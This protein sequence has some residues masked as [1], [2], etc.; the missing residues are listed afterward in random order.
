VVFPKAVYPLVLQGEQA[1]SLL[2][3]A[4]N[5]NRLVALFLQREG[6]GA[7][8]SAGD[9]YRVGT[10]SRLSEI[11]REPDG[12]IEVTAEGIAPVQLLSIKQWNPH[13]TAEVEAIEPLDEQD[14]ALESLAARTLEAYRGLVSADPAAAARLQPVIEETRDPLDVAYLVAATIPISPSARQAI[15]EARSPS[16]KLLQL[17]TFL[18]KAQEISASSHPSGEPPRNVVSLPARSASLDQAVLDRLDLE[19]QL[20]DAG[21]PPAAWRVAQREL[22][23]FSLLTPSSPDYNLVRTYLQWLAD[24]PWQNGSE[25]DIDLDRA[26]A[27]LD[28]D[29][30]GLEEVKLRIIEHL[31]VRK[32]RRQRANDNQ[33]GCDVETLPDV[34]STSG[35]APTQPVLCLVGPP[36]VGK[37]SLGRSISEALNRPF[38]RISLGG[39]SD[40]A[41]IRGHRRTYLGAM[42]GRIV[43]SLSRVES[44]QP[45]MMLDE[46]DK[47]GGNGKGDPTA[48]LLDV[49][50]PEQQ[51]EFVDH[52]IEVPFDV[53]CVFFLA[54]ANTLE[55]V[56]EALRDRLEVI[57]L[58]GYTEEEKAQIAARHLVPR[59]MLWH[60]LNDGDMRWE[61]DAIL[62]IIRS[63]TRE[64]GVRQLEREIATVCR[65]VATLVAQDG[66]TT[67]RFPFVID[68]A[69]VT[70]V[71]GTPRFLPAEPEATD[72]PGV[73]TGVFWTPVG[74]DIMH[75]EALMM[76]GS[77]TLTITGQ[78]GEVMR[79]SAQ[80]ALS[81]VRARAEDLRI[82]PD[83][84]E[85]H[86]LHLHIPSG[87]VAK[88]GPSAGIALAV[89]I[90]SL[91]TD[92][93]VSGD[94]AMTG[95]ITL[96]GR[97]LPVGGI[98]EKVL[99]A[100][101]AGVHKV[102]LPAQNRRD[103]DDVQPEILQDLELIF[104][105]T[106]D[107]VLAA[108]FPLSARGL[109]ASSK[110]PRKEQANPRA[111]MLDVPSAARAMHQQ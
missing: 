12:L 91:L 18:N 59:Q 70:D 87:A 50:D 82:A 22:D 68:S 23:R 21:M 28:R 61:P 55:S 65:R 74:G 7:E 36:G 81:Y 20:R 98:K 3:A 80:T 62:Q 107:E 106:M 54:T 14:P 10:L 26:R 6:V 45:V 97:V 76:P 110:A 90:V 43:Q 99:A 89:A 42:P 96:R 73:V 75:I 72:Q 85:R 40:E 38:V 41:E 39:V 93:P 16:A 17:L 8:P 27:I 64:A 109:S 30:Y 103:L 44:S 33:A 4:E 92:T 78:L 2:G 83:F 94:V 100:R 46:L 19:K 95:E 9:L 15:L 1:E 37:T 24:L 111:T 52:F 13:V 11:K 32:L 108:A 31:A 102:V 60:A 101:R 77:K 34:A 71:L 51:T 56:P 67:G 25:P 58:S 49:L 48:A 47:M 57:R 5:T 104:V 79:E 63:Y 88:D 66:D 105:D 69:F 35:Q 53:S 86:D 29:H 84:Y